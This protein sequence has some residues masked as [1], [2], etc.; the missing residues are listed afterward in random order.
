MIKPSNAKHAVWGGAELG[1]YRKT[2]YKIKKPLDQS[3]LFA[4][5]AANSN[6]M[7]AAVQMKMTIPGTGP[8]EVSFLPSI[9]FSPHP[10]FASSI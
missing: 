1:C 3:K 9:V 4:K 10:E 5:Q 7:S 8:A 2:Q 6:I